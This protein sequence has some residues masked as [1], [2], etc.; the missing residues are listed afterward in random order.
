MDAFFPTST[1]FFGSPFW[2]LRSTDLSSK[3]SI[4]KNT[5][6]EAF[7]MGDFWLCGVLRSVISIQ[8]CFEVIN[9]DKRKKSF[10]TF[11]QVLFNGYLFPMFT[12]YS[13]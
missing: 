11:S 12:S 2:S 10:V 3:Q 4:V 1:Y 6:L 7:Y 8:S 9:S 13:G 5:D